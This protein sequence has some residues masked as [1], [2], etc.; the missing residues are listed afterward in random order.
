MSINKMSGDLASG[1]EIISKGFV[2]E[3]KAY[4]LFAELKLMVSKLLGEL[5]PEVK[6]EWIIVEGMV[7]KSVG[8]YIFKQMERKPMIIP[9]ILEM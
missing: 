1:P 3:E 9:I 4:G 8:K 7:K 5:T 6:S 2:S